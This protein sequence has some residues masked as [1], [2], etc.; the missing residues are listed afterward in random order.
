VGKG[1]K[2]WERAGYKREL[3]KYWWEK[4]KPD[5]NSRNGKIWQNGVSKTGQV[6]QIATQKILCVTAPEL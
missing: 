3:M 1:D 6:L 2:N 4:V 5:G